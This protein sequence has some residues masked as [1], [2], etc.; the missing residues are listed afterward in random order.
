[1]ASSP[2]PWHPKLAAVLHHT[3]HTP[4]L[5]VDIWRKAI[6]V[7]QPW[8]VLSETVSHMKSFFFWFILGVF[9]VEQKADPHREE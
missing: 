7:K 8:T 9:S 4:K 5:Y 3:L 6:V 2:L 1:M